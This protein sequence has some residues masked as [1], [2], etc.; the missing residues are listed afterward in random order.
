MV[1]CVSFLSHVDTLPAQSLCH[2]PAAT[3]LRLVFKHTYEH[4]S[5]HTYIYD[6]PVPPPH[7]SG[8]RPKCNQ[9]F[10]RCL[11]LTW[12]CTRAYTCRDL[13]R[14]VWPGGILVLASVRHYSAMP[15]EGLCLVLPTSQSFT[16]LCI[17]LLI[18]LACPALIVPLRR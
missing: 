9:K 3:N 7:S 4:T 6:P 1:D 10:S 5:I 2:I 12:K 14:N 11:V 16:C 15:V 18:F 17:C 13:W 8:E